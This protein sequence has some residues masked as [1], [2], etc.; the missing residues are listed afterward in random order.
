MADSIKKPFSSK[1]GIDFGPSSQILSKGG[2]LLNE[3]LPRNKKYQTLIIFYNNKK[4]PILE[5]IASKISV[6]ENT[7]TLKPIITSPHLVLSLLS[8]NVTFLV[9]N[10]I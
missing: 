2:N 3:S 6:F 7:I 4:S 10:R 1:L 5:K 9:L 8:H